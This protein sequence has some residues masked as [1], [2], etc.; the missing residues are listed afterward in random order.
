MRDKSPSKELPA[1]KTP[2]GRLLP[3]S[4]WAYA[5]PIAFF[6]RDRSRYP[7]GHAAD[8]RHPEFPGGSGPTSIFFQARGTVQT[9]CGCLFLM[10]PFNHQVDHGP[11]RYSRTCRI[12]RTCGRSVSQSCGS[13]RLN[14]AGWCVTSV[15]RCGV[16]FTSKDRKA[17]VLKNLRE[18]SKLMQMLNSQVT[19]CKNKVPPLGDGDVWGQGQS[20]V[21]SIITM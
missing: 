16:I 12:K 17:E 6:S 2:V 11:A 19:K 21:A 3:A 7:G 13:R 14:N 18:K 9:G 15:T 4:H 5:K 8:Q 1:P 20:N 10:D